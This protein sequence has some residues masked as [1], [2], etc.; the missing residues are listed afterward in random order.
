LA[1]FGAN[2]GVGDGAEVCKGDL[3]GVADNPEV[4]LAGIILGT[5]PEVEAVGEEGVV[6]GLDEDDDD[7]GRAALAE[8]LAFDVFILAVGT[9]AVVIG[10]L[11][12]EALVCRGCA[13]SGMNSAVPSTVVMVYQMNLNSGTVS[14]SPFRS[15]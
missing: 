7:E 5:A 1:D 2:F 15:R 11:A 10:G 4:D 8:V 12:E 13:W 9:A 6:L 14:G 3:L